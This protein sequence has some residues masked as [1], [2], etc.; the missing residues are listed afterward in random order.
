MRDW[1]NEFFDF[2]DHASASCVAPELFRV[3]ELV[4]NLERLT[5]I[6]FSIRSVVRSVA[7]FA[8]AC[9]TSARVVPSV[10][11]FFA[12]LLGHLEEL[13]AQRRV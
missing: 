1:V 4:K 7:E 11:G 3:L 5:D 13:N 9:M 12:K 2:V 10:G 6:N 8:K